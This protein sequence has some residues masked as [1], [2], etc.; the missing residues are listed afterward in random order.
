LMIG[1]RP[2]KSD[3]TEKDYESIISTLIV[4]EDIDRIHP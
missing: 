3:Q 4:S 2:N 1:L